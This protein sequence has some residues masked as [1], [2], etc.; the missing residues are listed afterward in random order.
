MMMC[1]WYGNLSGQR[2]TVLQNTSFCLSLSHCFSFTGKKDAVLTSIYFWFS[3]D[4]L[5]AMLD[6]IS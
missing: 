3:G 5:G 2:G 6:N 1:L 4:T